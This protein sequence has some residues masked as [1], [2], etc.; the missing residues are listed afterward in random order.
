MQTYELDKIIQNYYDNFDNYI[1][2][3][4]NITDS[5]E[6]I[7]YKNRKMSIKL[8]MKKIILTILGISTL[9]G[10]IVLA[11]NYIFKSFK[12]GNGIDTAVENGYV[13]YPEDDNNDERIDDV[14]VQSSIEN[15]LMDDQNISTNFSFK[16][17]NEFFK[18]ANID[19]IIKIE[20]VD[21]IITD[22]NNIILYCANENTLNEFC[23]TNNLNYKFSEFNENYFNCGLNSFLELPVTDNTIHLTYNIYSG[24]LE[25][26][27]PKSRNLKYKFHEIKLIENYEENLRNK[28]IQGD[29][30]INVEVPEKM[31]NRHSIN[32][33]VA[34]CSDKN[35]EISTA[36]ISDT[37]FEF[38]C[39][40]KNVE[41]SEELKKLREEMK[42][43]STKSMSAEERE[44]IITRY[45]ESELTLPPINSFY[46]PE[47]GETIE[48][49]TYIENQNNE[50]FP[51]S[52]NP[53]RAQK[54]EFFDNDTTFVLYETFDIT[55]YNA[56]DELRINLK[57]YDKII[58]AKLVKNP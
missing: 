40:I 23:K 16:F 13:Y 2:V 39:I 14:T 3:P 20:L 37:G 28:V 34:E 45:M 42:S 15:F 47:F 21:L 41:L 53:G 24:G 57:F 25:N 12:L 55:K 44:K 58:T 49:C 51:I 17:N 27:Y 36:K 1:K 35:V 7:R 19:N 43:L 11:K 30:E 29:W 56:T 48:D 10:G 32:Y 46:Y 33:K 31:Y 5:I 18:N 54:E 38:G 26:S 50:K 9:T 6:N 52:S 4:K 8:L 22:E